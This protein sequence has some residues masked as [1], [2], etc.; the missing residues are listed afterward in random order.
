MTAA[1]AT[2]TTDADDADDDDDDDFQYIPFSLKVQNSSLNKTNRK[3]DV[4]INGTRQTLFKARTVR[5]F[6]NHRFNSV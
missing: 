2:S 5:E 4:S 6:V 1:A 3:V